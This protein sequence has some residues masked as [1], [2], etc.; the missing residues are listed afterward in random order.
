[1]QDFIRMTILGDLALVILAATTFLFGGMVLLALS[2]CDSSVDGPFFCETRISG[3]QAYALGV[4][5][6]T[7]AIP[8]LFIMATTL[9]FVLEVWN[10]TLTGVGVVGGLPLPWLLIRYLRQ[11]GQLRQS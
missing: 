6:C 2:F 11:K 9:T 8:L 7:I 1:M 5:F 10:Y 4:G 3:W